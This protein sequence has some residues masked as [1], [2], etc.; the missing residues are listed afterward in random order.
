M[1]ASN[2]ASDLNP[3]APCFK[4]CVPGS[5]TLDYR[6]RLVTSVPAYILLVLSL[7]LH[8]LLLGFLLG[9][10]LAAVIVAK[11]WMEIGRKM[12]VSPLTL[13]DS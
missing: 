1:A 4:C 11:A 10:A 7:P 5:R 12:W 13:S 9:I 8:P 6:M 3:D 2:R